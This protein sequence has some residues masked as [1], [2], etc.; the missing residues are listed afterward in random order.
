M[1]LFYL[2]KKYFKQC[3]VC[4]RIVQFNIPSLGHDWIIEDYE[5]TSEV[6]TKKCSRC[7]LITKEAASTVD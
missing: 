6:V 4:K 2:M 3:R 1:F 5:Q 7:G